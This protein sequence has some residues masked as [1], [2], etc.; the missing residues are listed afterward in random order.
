MTG[1]QCLTH[2]SFSL[3]LRR[4]F[5]HSNNRKPLLD[6]PIIE[7]MGAQQKNYNFS[8]TVLNLYWFRTL[9]YFSQIPMLLR[10]MGLHNS[11]C[12]L[13]SSRL[14]QDCLPW[15]HRY[16]LDYG[17]IVLSSSRLRTNFLHQEHQYPLD[18]YPLL[19]DLPLLFSSN[20]QCSGCC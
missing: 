18:L 19:P 15:E 20:Y 2:M 3:N 4:T 6:P 14:Q 1:F 8:M 5:R 13:L 7:A 10:L 12:H 11:L 16:P 9:T 17:W